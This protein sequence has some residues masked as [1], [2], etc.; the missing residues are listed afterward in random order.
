M[1]TLTAFV[2]ADQVR[3][4]V[5]AA[6][7]GHQ[8]EH[9]LG[10]AEGRRGVLHGAVGAVQ[11]DLEAAAERQPVDEAERRLAAVAELAEHRV[12]EPAR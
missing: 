1:I 10:Q 6:P 7:A 12:A 11:R 9:H 5:G 3:H 4:Q 2:G 8:A